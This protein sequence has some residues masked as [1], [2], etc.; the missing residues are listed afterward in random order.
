[1]YA[2]STPAR[3]DACMTGACW[4]SSVPSAV[5]A[6]RHG[7]HPLPRAKGRSADVHVRVTIFFFFLLSLSAGIGDT[8]FK[9][10][11]LFTRKVL[12]NLT[13]CAAHARVQWESFLV[14]NL[15]PPYISVEADVVHRVLA[16][17]ANDPHAPILVLCSDGLVDFFGGEMAPQELA[18]DWARAL[19]RVR[20]QVATT[21]PTAPGG[22]PANLAVELLRHALGGDAATVSSMLRYDLEVDDTSIVVAIL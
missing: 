22:G 8:P 7:V 17:G 18:D 20:S 12:Y 6:A 10:A 3:L 9:L 4:A 15:T 14:R 11:P 13:G 21:M 2:R 5:S 16:G 19:G 1:V